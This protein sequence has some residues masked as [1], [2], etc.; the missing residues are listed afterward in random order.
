MENISKSPARGGRD[1]VVHGCRAPLPIATRLADG[2]AATSRASRAAQNN[3]YASLQALCSD[4]RIH[5]LKLCNGRDAEIRHIAELTGVAFDTLRFNTPRLDQQGWFRLGAERIKA[6]AFT[7]SGGQVCPACVLEGRTDDARNGAFQKGIWQVSS[8]HCCLKHKV[9]LVPLEVS[10]NSKSV[11]DFAQHVKSWVPGE[12]TEVAD[13]DLGLAVYLTDRIR[14]GRGQAWLDGFEF[15]VVSSFVEALGTLLKFGSKARPH[16]LSAP[17]LIKAGAAGYAVARHGPDAIRNALD[18]IRTSAPKSQKPD[19]S[20]IYGPVIAELRARRNDPDF[21]VLRHLIREYVLDYF[22][23]PEGTSLLGETCGAPRLLTVG[24]ASKRSGIPISTLTRQL[25]RDGELTSE[26]KNGLSDRAMLVSA[27]VMDAAIGEAE[28]LT[29]LKIAR[30]VLGCDRYTMERLIESGMMPLHFPAGEGSLPMLHSDE[31]LNFVSRL[32]AVTEVRSDLGADDL[33]LA[34]VAR[35]C[36]CTMHWLLLTALSGNLRLVSKL[37]EP[38]RLTEFYVSL[39]EVRDQLELV[40]EGHV[41]VAQAAKLLGCNVATIHALAEGGFVG[42]QFQDARLSNRKRRVVSLADLEAFE[43]DYIL[44]RALS[45][46][47]RADFEA[48]QLQLSEQGVEPLQLGETARKF[49]KRVEIERLAYRPGGHALARLL[50]A[51][52]MHPRLSDG[53]F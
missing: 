18:T 10:G 7:R 53:V 42:S 30:E 45:G 35:Q 46:T 11:H 38:F 43:R 17:E 26:M 16:L 31:I 44:L 19:Y 36:H 27:T 28:K 6:T 3:G 40:P 48:L 32:Q 15:H 50:A 51:D 25:K 37:K 47:R 49:F 14:L 52:E 23:V 20:K 4:Q 2:E 34:E 21:D 41:T 39:S 24:V 33:L 5:V 1:A 9:A 22:Y 12:I 13:E 8:L 29:S